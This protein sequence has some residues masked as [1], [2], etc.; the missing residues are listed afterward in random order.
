MTSYALCFYA[1]ATPTL[2]QGASVPPAGGKW[3]AIG[4]KGYKYKDPTGTNA[5]I[6]K[7]IVK[8]GAAGKSKALVKGKGADLPAFDTYLPI[9][10]GN[11]PLIVQLRNNANGLCWQGSFATPTK[12]L[13]TQFNAKAP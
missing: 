8:G 6:T 3:S 9:A 11:L 7:I 5:G 10:T 12:N 2:L 4:T 1:G 13:S